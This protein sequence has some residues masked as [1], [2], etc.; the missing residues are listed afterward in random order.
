MPIRI[1]YSSARLFNFGSVPGCASV[2]TLTCV[3]GADPN[4]V[5]S[6]VKILLS[7]RSC[8]WTSNPITALYFFVKSIVDCQRSTVDCRQWTV[9]FLSY[10]FLLLLEN[11]I[12]STQILSSSRCKERLPSSSTI[13]FFSKFFHHVASVIAVFLR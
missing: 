11:S 1:A 5:E 13:N 2:I 6:E 10:H 8:A 4:A 3:L 12:Q 9:D 7:V